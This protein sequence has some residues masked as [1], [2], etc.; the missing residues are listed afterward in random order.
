PSAVNERMERELPVAGRLQREHRA[1]RLEQNP[2]RIAPHEELAHRRALA[3]TDHDQLSTLGLRDVQDLVSRIGALGMA[4]NPEI[5][6]RISKTRFQ[7][8]KLLRINEPVV[9]QLI[10]LGRVHH[11]QASLAVPGFDNGP[12]QGGFTFRRGNVAHY[13]RHDSFLPA[14]WLCSVRWAGSAGSDWSPPAAFS[15]SRASA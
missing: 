9:N 11:D 7:L 6:A 2:L 3:Q 8:V 10:A 5:D 15:P 12:F 4:F 1:S 13:D 14:P